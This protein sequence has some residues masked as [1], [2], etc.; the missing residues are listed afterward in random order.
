MRTVHALFVVAFTGVPA[1]AQLPVAPPPSPAKTV[2]VAV[3]AGPG[4]ATARGPVA[5][6][7]EDIPGY[8]ADLVSP[9]DIRA[10]KL[11]GYQLVIVPG[12]SGGGQAG[13]LGEEGRAKVREFVKGGG[14][15]VGICAGSYLASSSYTWSLNI[16]AADVLDKAHWARGTGPVG[17]KYSAPGK[18]FFG[19]PGDTVTI[20]YGQGPL[21]APKT[22]ADKSV[23]A[24]EPLAVYEGEIYS[25][26]GATPG[27]MKGTTAAARGSYG[28]G[29]VF[30]FSP[31]PEKTDS[32]E[33]RVMF[34]K[35]VEWA[36]GK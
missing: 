9:E 6:H 18:T 29:R 19:P 10:G 23:P 17:L 22:V 32:D 13:A 4:A 8:A 3:Y 36:A 2:R 11:A 1:A 5:A 20:Y 24:Y 16:L 31:H 33:A 12:G 27:V 25:R 30:C 35:A 14:G 21:L 28:A 7:V 26:G 34:R 15:Y